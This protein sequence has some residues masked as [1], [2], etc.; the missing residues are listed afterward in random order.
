VCASS[1]SIGVASCEFPHPHP[2]S[3]CRLFTF[4][5]PLATCHLPLSTCHL[6]L[7]TIIDCYYMPS[8]RCYK[9]LTSCYLH[10]RLS[11]KN[12]LPLD[13]CAVCIV[14]CGKWEVVQMPRMIAMHTETDASQGSLD[15]H[16]E[17]NI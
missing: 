5:F 14:E 4:H 6:P 16:S 12:A 3:H 15:T 1:I 11:I 13:Q 2:T 8:T 9:S 10:A 17:Q 7:A